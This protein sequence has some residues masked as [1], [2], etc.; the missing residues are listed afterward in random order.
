MHGFP[1]YSKRLATFM[2]S[3]PIAIIIA[4]VVTVGAMGTAAVLAGNILSGT[5]TATDLLPKT[6]EMHSI[7]SDHLEANI[8]FT[9][10]GSGTL[11][12]I[13]AWVE[14]DYADGSATAYHRLDVQTDTVEP[15]KTLVISGSVKDEKVNAAD[16][17]GGVATKRVAYGVVNTVI[18][19]DASHADG[20]WDVYP[21]ESILLRVIASTT[22]GDNI[23]KLHKITVK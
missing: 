22:S 20:Y 17:N 21:G 9:N 13:D 14:I 1:F 7:N 15:Y 11:E 10:Q 16:D 3:K 8:Q 23:E 12:K 18:P 5:S 19:E 4:I 6:V 2:D